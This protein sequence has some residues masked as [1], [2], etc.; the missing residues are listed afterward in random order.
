MKKMNIREIERGK[1]TVINAVPGSGKTTTIIHNL[2]L[3]HHQWGIPQ[4]EILAT[5]FTKAMAVEMGERCKEKKLADVMPTTL[6]AFCLGLIREDPKRFGFN[7]DELKDEN[8]LDEELY[9][10]QQYDAYFDDEQPT[11]KEP[12]DK[13]PISFSLLKTTFHTRYNR[14]TKERDFLKEAKVPAEKIDETLEFFD[15]YRRIKREENKLGFHDMINL[16]LS[17]L[18]NDPG[19]LDELCK[20]FQLL[21]VDEYQ[22]LNYPERELAVLLAQHMR[23][24]LIVGDDLQAVHLYRGAK[25]GAVKQLSKTFENTNVIE[26]NHSYRVTKPQAE[27]LRPVLTKRGHKPIVS[28]LPGPPPHIIEANSRDHMYRRALTTI[29]GLQKEGVEEKDI[30]VVARFGTSIQTFARYLER[31]SIP[32]TVTKARDRRYKELLKFRSFLRAV[33]DDKHLAK[34][35]HKMAKVDR[36]TA[37]QL[38]DLNKQIEAKELGLTDEQHQ[39]CWATRDAVKHVREVPSAQVQRRTHRALAVFAATQGHKDRTLLISIQHVLRVENI[40]FDHTTSIQELLQRVHQWLLNHKGEKSGST[41]DITLSTTHG[42]KGRE[43]QHVLILDGYDENLSKNGELPVDE[44]AEFNVFYVAMTRAKVRSH[45]FLLKHEAAIG[46][47]EFKDD[48]TQPNKNEELV[49]KRAYTDLRFLP[50]YT[51]AK[52]LCQYDRCKHINLD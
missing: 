41:T 24:V 34:S 11:D 29:I 1:L 36:K 47:I 14:G 42:A 22:D 37:R 26:L 39:K 7:F 33:L 6:H 10:W 4:H 51:K 28:T 23:T 30:A 43:W 38:T 20:G 17:Q 13:Q 50:P 27:F 46:S 21:A 49:E 48:K 52:G 8:V 25:I 15:H 19:Y 5:T 45:L 40:G 35:I 31:R 16:V 18:K 9:L 44:E 12:T 3:A 32:F 2:G